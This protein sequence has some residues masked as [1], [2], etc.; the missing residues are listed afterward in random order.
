MRTLAAA[1]GAHLILHPS[2]PDP[3]G[4]AERRQAYTDWLNETDE[5]EKVN[6]WAEYLRLVQEDMPKRKVG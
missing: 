2:T 5:V 6:K 4:D 1:V 3:Y